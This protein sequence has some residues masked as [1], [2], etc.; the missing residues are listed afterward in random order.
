MGLEKKVRTAEMSVLNR[1]GVMADLPALKEK[2]L[3]HAIKGRVPVKMALDMTFASWCDQL[4]GQNVRVPVSRFDDPVP[5][6][7]K[8]SKLA[9]ARDLAKSFRL[10]TDSSR[11]RST[12]LKTGL[13]N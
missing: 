7:T 10:V 2:Q 5:G 9:V 8:L 4:L 3:D 6:K 12:R 13:I 11:P 1:Y